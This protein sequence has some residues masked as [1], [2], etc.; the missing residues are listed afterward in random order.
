MPQLLIFHLVMIIT[1]IPHGN[2]LKK[3]YTAV[4]HDLNQQEVSKKASNSWLTYTDPFGEN[5]GSMITI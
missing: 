4:T 5:E 1:K 2:G 3:Q